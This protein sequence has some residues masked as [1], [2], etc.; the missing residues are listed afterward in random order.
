M[1]GSYKLLT[2]TDGE[3]GLV[4]HPGPEKLSLVCTTS[5][6]SLLLKKFCW[7]FEITPVLSPVGVSRALQC[8]HCLEL[9]LT[10]RLPHY[11]GCVRAFLAG[12]SCREREQQLSQAGSVA[13]AS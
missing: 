6:S 13:A 8:A 5:F 10:D 7:I 12:M 4:F 9:A 2:N 1:Q 11:S 3:W